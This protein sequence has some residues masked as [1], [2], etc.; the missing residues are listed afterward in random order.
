MLKYP[1][2][3]GTAEMFQFRQVDFESEIYHAI[4][5]VY[6]DD[7]KKEALRFFQKVTAGKKKS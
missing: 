6:P 7:L 1:E 4:R 2:N 3:G 5:R